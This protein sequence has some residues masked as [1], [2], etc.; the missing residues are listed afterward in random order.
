MVCLIGPERN[1]KHSGRTANYVY[2][3]YFLRVKNQREFAIR[4]K[5]SN[6]SVLIHLPGHN[7]YKIRRHVKV[8]DNKSPYDGDISYWGQRLRAYGGLSKRAILLLR[9]QRGAC[10]ACGLNFDFDSVMEVD[11]IVPL[12]QSGKDQYDNLQLL[13]AHCH[14]QKSNESFISRSR[15][16]GNLHVRF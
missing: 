4:V 11:H 10:K 2:Q 13:H 16:K 5:R 3:N 15:M 7:S 8:R 1:M 14:D 9:T 12:S 6:K